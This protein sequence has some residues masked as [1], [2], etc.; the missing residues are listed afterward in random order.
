METVEAIPAGNIAAIGGMKVVR[1]G[2]TLFDVKHIETAKPFEDVKYVSEPV[3]TVAV[4]PD[5][6]KELDKLE[7]ILED[8]Q[9]EDPNISA[10]VSADTGEVLLSGMGP[11][12][13]EITAKNIQERGINI[14]VSKPTSVFRESADHFSNYHEATSPNNQNKIKMLIMRLNNPTVQY[15]RRAK[16]HVLEYDAI[17]EKELPLHTSFSEHEA[18]GMWNV[19][20]YQN[21][22]ISRLHE[23]TGVV[24][25]EDDHAQETPK[26]PTKKGGDRKVSLDM[27]NKI[28]RGISELCKH[29]I[30]AQEPLTELKIIIKDIEIAGN[31]DDSNFFEL[32]AM[33]Q[34]VF[35]KCI[36]EANP[37]LLEPIYKLMLTS[38]IG[39]IGTV[40]SL[41]NQFQGKILE[42]D[43]DNYRAFI[44]AHMSVRKSIDFVEEI[45][46]KTSGR[47]FWQAILD[48]FQPVPEHSKDVII[49]D[50]KFRKGLF[51]F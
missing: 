6:L 37:I 18:R 28:I 32:S 49:Q 45:R 19:D 23:D 29:G 11:L 38:P 20:N 42:V 30:I 13:L 34:D 14:S 43:Q 33:I 48:S 39:L 44:N 27:R 31:I 50:I 46:N 5:M 25:D 7:K 12:H 22:I 24:Y 4:E 2:E 41:I 51:T 8:I 35:M 3:V 26:S 15:L 1:S 10:S 17:R 16:S 9:I 40:T 36:Q 47:V 21:V